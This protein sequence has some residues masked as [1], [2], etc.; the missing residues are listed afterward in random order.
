M[1]SKYPV[2]DRSRLRVRPLAEREHDMDLGYLL[3]QE[4]GAGSA[5]DEVL[6]NDFAMVGA[7]L[8]AILGTPQVPLIFALDAR[9]QPQE[10]LD[11]QFQTDV[12]LPPLQIGVAV[13]IYVPFLDFN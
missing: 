3:D 9:W 5:Q 10:P 2:F 13:G 1:Q 7:Q 11:T 8:G 6:W 4:T 12:G